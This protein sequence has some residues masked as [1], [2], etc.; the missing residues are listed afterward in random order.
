MGADCDE[1]CAC[2][3]I[4]PVGTCGF[5][6]VFFVEESHGNRFDGGGR[7]GIASRL[8]DRDYVLGGIMFGEGV[9]RDV[10]LGRGAIR[11]GMLSRLYSAE[12]LF[13]GEDGADVG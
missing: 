5:H 1:I 8:R 11:D 10:D 12:G 6:T 7:D 3:V 2:G 9:I 13:A 4:M